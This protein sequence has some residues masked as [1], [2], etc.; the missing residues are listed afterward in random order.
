[1]TINDKKPNDERSVGAGAKASR[2]ERARRRTSNTFTLR[3]EY[4]PHRTMEIGVSSAAIKPSYVAHPLSIAEAD[5]QPNWSREFTV[6]GKHTLEQLNT[7]ILNVLGWDGGHLYEFRIA[8]R[9]YAHMVF[10]DEDDLFVEAENSCVS[11]DIPI[12]CLGFSAGDSF[13][14]IYSMTSA[15]TTFFVSW[16]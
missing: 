7:I 13:A 15:T 12:R 3:I 6:D 16:C 14:Y 2:H 10:L 5:I 1:M 4:A 8:G 11:C 9:L